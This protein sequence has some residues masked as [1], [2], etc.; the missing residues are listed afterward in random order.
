[1]TQH[2]KLSW[3]FVFALAGTL[4]LAPSRAG[5]E[6][7]ENKPGKLRVNSFPS[8]AN[9]SLDGTDTGKVT[10]MSMEV[11]VGWHKVKVSIPNSSWN[12]DVR[13][14]QVAA[15]NNDL[16]ITL[17]PIMSVGPM[18]PPGPAGPAG[19][20]GPQGPAGAI[21]PAGPQG[22]KGDTGAT[23][24]AGATGATGPMGTVGPMG[25]QGSK[26][27]TGATGAVGPM[28][29]TGAMGPQGPAGPQ[30][31]KGD[32]GATGAVGATGATG[33]AGPQGPAGP[34]G[35]TGPQGPAG[36]VG[37]MG[38]QGP[39]G[40]MGNVGQ[41]GATGATGPQGAA[42]PPGPGLNGR[43]EFLPTGGVNTFTFVVPN[44]V[45]KLSVELYGAGGGGAKVTCTGE[46]GGG[47]GAYTSTI[48][49]VQEGQSLTITVGASGL[50][51]TAGVPA[52]GNGG[53]TEVLDAN[54]TVLAV[55]HGGNGGQPNLPTGVTCGM[56]TPGAAGG[57]PDPNAAISHSG[58]SAPSVY[59][60]NNVGAVGYLIPGFPFQPN[61]QFGGGGTGSFFP[62]QVGQG[63]GGYALLTW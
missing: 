15:G 26:G 41:T 57:A 51:G 46:G 56:N 13:D 1:M 8:G 7:K 40:P 62:A 16:S 47:G 61:G 52:G 27:D 17:L 30:G 53:D 9:V 23:G 37:P 48:V 14:V 5:A 49:S 4:F 58:P 45:N 25:P 22:P 33:P 55:A 6:D 31:P 39:Q 35:A 50:A 36:P 63:Q 60:A 34:I 28:G 44:G 19:P 43:Q 24:A 54:N 20:A 3:I 10:P 32:T 12:A 21:G 42:G 29:P 11:S 38:P 18:G 59:S 2:R